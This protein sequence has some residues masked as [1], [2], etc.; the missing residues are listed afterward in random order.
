[1]TLVGPVRPLLLGSLLGISLLT[2]CGGAVEVPQV[3]EK[4]AEEKRQEYEAMIK[5]ERANQ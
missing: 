1:M 4:T 2:G 3:D 5:K